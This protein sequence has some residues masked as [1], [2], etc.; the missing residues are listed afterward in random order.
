MKLWRLVVLVVLCVA[1]DVAVIGG[2]GVYQ[3]M[4]V[5]SCVKDGECF[6]ISRDDLT[7]I[8]MKSEAHAARVTEQV[9]GQ[10]AYDQGRADGRAVCPSLTSWGKFD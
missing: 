7:Q 10:E 9:V 8:V 4:Q 5:E 2:V 1:L 6:Y 3:T